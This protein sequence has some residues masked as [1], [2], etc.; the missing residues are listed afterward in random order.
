[1]NTPVLLEIH[2]N[3]GARMGEYAGWNLPIH[4]GSV[5]KEVNAVR[6][7]AGLFDVSHMGRF[8]LTGHGALP[9][10][11]QLLTNDLGRLSD[12]AGQLTLLCNPSGGIKDDLIAYRQSEERYLLV[13]NAANAQKDKAWIVDHLP[14]GVNLLDVTSETVLFALQGPKSPEILRRAEL[15]QA[16]ETARFHFTHAELNGFGVLI[17]R[18]GYTGEDG[19]EIACRS[20]HA[21][22]LWNTILTAGEELGVAPCGLAAR[23]VLRL[24]AGYMLYGHEMDEETTPVEAGLMWI[25][26]T[27]KGDF[28]GR[29]AI[30]EAAERGRARRILGVEMEGRFVPRSDDAVLTS[31]G[32]G[33]ATS[34]TFSPTLGRGIAISYLPPDVREGESVEVVIHGSPRSGALRRLPFYS[35]K[36]A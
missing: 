15:P 8:D 35:R 13:V 10:L 7:A 32:E 9:A 16:A 11:Q 22:E 14:E 12:G 28:V 3:A 18:T 4:Y 29:A 6:T 17:S 19:F 36:I 24:E 21:A 5:I 2:Q 31:A 20:E 26:K 33:R 30:L 1:M 27:E 34:G 23:D 25:V